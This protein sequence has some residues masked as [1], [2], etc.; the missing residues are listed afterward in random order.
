MVDVNVFII[1]NTSELWAEIYRKRAN[2][3]TNTFEWYDPAAQINQRDLS[4]SGQDDV[5]K[6][7]FREMVDY[8]SEVYCILSN[9]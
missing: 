4:L 5:I 8:I 2:A 7:I 6:E 3:G 1:S 9:V